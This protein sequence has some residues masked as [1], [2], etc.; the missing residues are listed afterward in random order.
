MCSSTA[1]RR[2]SSGTPV[3]AHATIMPASAFSPAGGGVR[4]AEAKAA[5]RRG[6]AWH[7]PPVLRTGGS[8]APTSR[9]AGSTATTPASR[10]RMK[11]ARRRPASASATAQQQA[12]RLPSGRQRQ[13]RLGLSTNNEF[14]SHG[15]LDVLGRLATDRPVVAKFYG[16]YNIGQNT[17]IGAFVYAGSGTP[18]TTYVKTGQQYGSLRRGPWRH[19]PHADVYNKTDLLVSHELPDGQQQAAVRAERVEPLQSEDGAAHFQHSESWSGRCLTPRRRSTWR[20][21]ISTRGMTTTR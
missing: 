2:I 14:D 19:G 5:V 21:P 20:R 10:A 3:R 12:V 18:M 16:G 13:P 8:E 1:T 6:G 9:S 4:D 11:S 7:Q 15:T 17:Q